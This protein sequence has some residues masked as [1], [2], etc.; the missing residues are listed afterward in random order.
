MLVDSQPLVW[1]MTDDPRL[2]RGAR[3]LLDAV[4]F[5]HYSALSVMELTMKSLSLG[6]NGKPKLELP[7]NFVQQ[8]EAG[9]FKELPLHSEAAGELEKFLLLHN[10]DPMDRM[11]LAQAS[12]NGMRLLTADRMLLT[13]GLDWVVDSQE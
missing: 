7:K 1:F 12:K 9:G 5:L 4:P 13:L 10:H 6:P 11:L 8:L 2:G 3:R